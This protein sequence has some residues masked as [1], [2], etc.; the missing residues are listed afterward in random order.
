[1]AEVSLDSQSPED[2]IA[3]TLR[4]AKFEA[5]RCLREMA[6]D[7][8]DERPAYVYALFRPDGT[9]RYVGK[10]TGDRIQEH[11]RAG[12]R[13]PNPRLAADYAKF[14]NLFAFKV[15]E[16]VTHDE[17]FTVES[18]LIHF[19]GIEADGLGPLANLDYGGRGGA[20]KS[21]ETIARIS[22]ASK[23]A[24]A[25]PETKARL[26]AA[27]KEV[28]KRP[29]QKEKRGAS[30]KIALANPDVKARQGAGISAAFK[31][32]KLRLNRNKAISEAHLRPETNAKL[33]SN[34]KAYW[35]KCKQV[36]ADALKNPEVIARRN[37][38]IS[39][40]LQKP[41]TKARKSRIM[42]ERFKNQEERN[43]V[44]RRSREAQARPDVKERHKAGLKRYNESPE[45]RSK[46]SE[47]GKNNWKNPEYVAKVMAARKAAAERRKA[48][49]QPPI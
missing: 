11:G 47:T 24:L 40:G 49:K 20:E 31:D 44:G 22:A 30:I 45:G 41:E 9:I 15:V 32:D 17:A 43:A 33:R 42:I 3:Q 28:H 35:S 48:I 25:R 23:K 21:S 13:H 8:S 36:V 18:V 39:A 14:Q 38:S 5:E 1:M 19:L 10:G 4:T 6:L 46:K 7:T 27:L 12:I 16:D 37:A 26:S 34:S 2:K 29:G